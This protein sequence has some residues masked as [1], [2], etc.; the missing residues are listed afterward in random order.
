MGD[1]LNK[2]KNAV[3]SGNADLD[4]VNKFNEINKN[5]NSIKV[6]ED[7]IKEF[8][9]RNREFAKSKIVT[10]E[11]TL[12]ANKIFEEFMKKTLETDRLNAMN[13]VL[14]ELNDKFDDLNL[15]VKENLA[16]VLEIEKGILNNAIQLPELTAKIVNI[17]NKCLN[18]IE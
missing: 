7:S 13:I 14:L 9:E 18:F 1:F 11:E 3:E 15:I 5:A 12:E 6:T 4:I 8:E 17:K 16:H 10:K 2:L